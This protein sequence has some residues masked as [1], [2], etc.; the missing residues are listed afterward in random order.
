MLLGEVV[1]LDQR[2]IADKAKY[3]VVELHYSILR[4]ANPLAE[5]FNISEVYSQNTRQTRDAKSIEFGSSRM[6]T[7]NA[8]FFRVAP[9]PSFIKTPQMIYCYA[10]LQLALLFLLISGHFQVK[11]FLSS[12]NAISDHTDLNRFK[13]LARTNMYLSLV[14][15]IL[16]VP[17]IAISMYLGYAY[18]I[19]GVAGVVAVNLPQLLFARNLRPLERAACQLHCSNDLSSEF[20]IIGE[21]WFKK[22]LPNF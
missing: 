10:M 21:A 17:G 19:A 4:K 8:S 7:D 22:A 9:Y 6:L 13:S 2:R 14:Y 5:F 11:R 3:V 15:M 1:Y 20:R 18:G 16:T 12:H